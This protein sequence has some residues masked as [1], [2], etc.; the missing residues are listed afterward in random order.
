MS[1]LDLSYKIVEE[2][3]SSEKVYEGSTV[4]RALNVGSSEISTIFWK[5]RV[6]PLIK[7]T[8]TKTHWR[9]PNDLNYSISISSDVTTAAY[10]FK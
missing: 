6:Y 5:L 8:Y 2:L 4:V 7:G 10:F 1:F 9:K 3:I